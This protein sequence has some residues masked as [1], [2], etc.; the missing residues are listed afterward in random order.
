MKIR[1][2]F[3]EQ[4]VGTKWEPVSVHSSYSVAVVWAAAV[5]MIDRDVAR[6]FDEEPGEYRV[7]L[8]GRK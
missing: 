7:T 2:Y 4:R 5:M 3:V 1:K 8:W 6:E